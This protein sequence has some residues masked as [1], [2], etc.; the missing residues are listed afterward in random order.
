MNSDKESS[1]KSPCIKKC[2]LNADHICT[3][4]VRTIQEIAVWP[5]V[6]NEER[7]EIRVKVEPRRLSE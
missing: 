6:D 2:R 1:V 7:K 5:D 4:S 3:D